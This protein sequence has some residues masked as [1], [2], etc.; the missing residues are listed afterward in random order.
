MDETIIIYHGSNA[1][2]QKPK[3]LINGHL[4]YAL[5]KK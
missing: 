1:I 4:K 3:I 2:V 5:S